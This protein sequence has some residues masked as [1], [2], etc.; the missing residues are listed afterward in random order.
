MRPVEFPLIVNNCRTLWG[1]RCARVPTGMS[2]QNPKGFSTTAGNFAEGVAR[3]HP[4]TA[5]EKNERKDTRRHGS[6]RTEGSCR[7]VAVE[8]G[9]SAAARQTRGAAFE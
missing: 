1:Q 5:E 7:A 8:D 3:R 6:T 2:S 9:C 4:C